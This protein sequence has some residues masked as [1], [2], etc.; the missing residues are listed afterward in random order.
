MLLLTFE[1]SVL[2]HGMWLGLIF[3]ALNWKAPQTNSKCRFLVLFFQSSKRSI[4]GYLENK[5][6]D[7]YK[8]FEKV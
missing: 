3:T 2:S 6:S 5:D 1:E 8:N 7:S 4:I